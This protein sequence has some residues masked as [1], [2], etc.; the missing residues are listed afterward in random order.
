MNTKKITAIL[1]AV[2]LLSL[3][4][5]AQNKNQLKQENTHLKSVVDSLNRELAKTRAELQYTDSLASELLALYADSEVK[6][7][8]KLMPED[9]TA[10]I[11]D[12]L[13]NLWY[14]QNLVSQSEEDLYDMDSVKF[15]SNVPDSVYIERIK[16]MNSFISLP[17][18]SVVKNHI[19][20]YSEKM[21]SSIGRILGLYEYY[22]PYFDE[23]FDRY[24]MP[25]ELKAMAIIE[26]AMNPLAVS[27]AGAKGMWQFMY[28]TAKIYGLQIDSIVDERLDPYKAA[29]AAA[30]YLQDAYEIYGDWNLAI[31]SYNCGA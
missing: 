30:Q 29:E 1:I 2:A 7:Q 23:I 25:E 21:P 12:S 6:N 13:L 9:Y 8:G 28:S 16:M 31:A 10:E 3:S 27:R 5:A 22:K 15:E 17:Y 24:N 11:S 20:K 19:I 18:N 26:S 4:A 14:V